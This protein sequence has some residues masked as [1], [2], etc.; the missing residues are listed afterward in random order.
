MKKVIVHYYAF[1]EIEVPDFVADC[2]NAEKDFPEN[3]FNNKY[4]DA[5][6]RGLDN[7]GIDRNDLNEIF[8]IERED[9]LGIWPLWQ[10]D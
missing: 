4:W 5:I 8:A 10:N 1:T 3:H 6:I 9:E 2:T 7:A